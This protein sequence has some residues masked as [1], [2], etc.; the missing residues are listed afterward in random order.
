MV[1]LK[2]KRARCFIRQNAG[3]H[4][5]DLRAENLNSLGVGSVIVIEM[6]SVIIPDIQDTLLWDAFTLVGQNL[7]GAHHLDQ[8]NLYR[9]KRRSEPIMLCYGLVRVVDG[10]IVGHILIDSSY[11]KSSRHI[12]DI[13]KPGILERFDGGN[14]K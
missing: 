10:I 9:A 11:A 14:I 7:V 4:I 5:S 12:H 13:I 3:Q 8:R 1:V 6:V 2:L